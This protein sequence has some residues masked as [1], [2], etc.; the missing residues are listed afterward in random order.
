MKYLFTTLAVGDSY[1]DNA[2][3]CYKKLGKVL[4]NC[5]FNITTNIKLNNIDSINFNYFSLDKYHDDKPGFSFYLNLKVLALKYALDKEYD[6]VIYNDAD[7]RP[8]EN[9]QENKILQLF[10]Y[11]NANNYDLLFERPAQ[12]GYYKQHFDECY[13]KEKF[14]DYN[15]FEHNKWDNAHVMNEQFFVYKV[16]WKYRFFV[17]RWEQFLWYTIANDIRSYPD[18][19]EIGVSAH[20]ADMVADYDQWRAII[21]DCFEFF[22]KS[23]NKHIRF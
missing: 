11:M 6:F 16:N 5:N 13:F 7:W 19:F 15:V 2:I 8:T 4:S 20:E 9:L 17:R 3:D 1:L 22:D 10:E 23:G 18:G 21:K 14:H 12:I